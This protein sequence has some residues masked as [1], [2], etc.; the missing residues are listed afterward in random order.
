MTEQFSVGD[1]VKLIAGSKIKRSFKDGYWMD[2]TVQQNDAFLCMVLEHVRD[3]CALD[4]FVRIGTFN[5]NGVKSTW[6]MHSCTF[7]A[8]PEALKML[9]K[10]SPAILE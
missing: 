3:D 6:L 4:G 2:F 9:C 1:L 8:P 7:L 5:A 10:L